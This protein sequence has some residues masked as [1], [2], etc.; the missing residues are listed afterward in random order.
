MSTN[1]TH[2]PRKY[3]PYYNSRFS[4]PVLGWDSEGVLFL[5]LVSWDYLF[6]GWVNSDLSRGPEPE[7]Y[8]LEVAKWAIPPLMPE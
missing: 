8:D 4:I 6:N 1:E 7:D 3:D 5:N 2:P